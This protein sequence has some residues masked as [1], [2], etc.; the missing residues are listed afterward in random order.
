MGQ[1]IILS[2]LG[3]VMGGNALPHFVR[4]ITRERYPNMTGNGPVTNFISGWAGLVLAVLLVC[5]A[6]ADRHPVWAFGSAAFGVLLIGLFHA[7]PGAFGRR[8]PQRTGPANE[9]PR[10]A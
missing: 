9:T 7:G 8:E 4:G 6:H 1:T 2:F 10:S 5:W 3:G